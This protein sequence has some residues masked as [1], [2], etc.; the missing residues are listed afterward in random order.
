MIKSCG[1][2]IEIGDI[3]KL[4]KI[5]KC[6]MN[7]LSAKR[8]SDWI[9]VIRESEGAVAAGADSASQVNATPSVTFSMMFR[10][11][12]VPTTSHI[13]HNLADGI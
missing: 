1:Q 7:C 5:E 11:L 4:D 10:R 9:S 13:L 6:L 8:V 3:Q 12:S 2:H